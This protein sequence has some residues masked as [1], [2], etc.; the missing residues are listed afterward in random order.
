M[1]SAV[2]RSDASWNDTH[3]RNP[4]FDRLL[5]EARVELDEAR[6][7]EMYAE[8]QRMVSEDGGVIIPMYANFVWARNARVAHA[9]SVASNWSL[10]GWRSVERW[11]FA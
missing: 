8:M 7:A 4:D 2:Y 5:M 1:F 9:D 3:W 6:R 10:D 11:W